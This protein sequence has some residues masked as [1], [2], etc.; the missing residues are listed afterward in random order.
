MP[1]LADWRRRM[2]QPAENISGEAGRAMRAIRSSFS[3]GDTFG[4]PKDDRIA[5]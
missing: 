1:I 2:A 5:S 3:A 4:A